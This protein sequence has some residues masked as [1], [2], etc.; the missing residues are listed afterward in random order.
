MLEDS[1][2]KRMQIID[3]LESS[4]ENRRDGESAFKTTPAGLPVPGVVVNTS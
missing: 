4:V 2:P 1:Q 3:D